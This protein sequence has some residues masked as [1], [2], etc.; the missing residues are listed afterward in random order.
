M[1]FYVNVSTPDNI[2]KRKHTG[3]G[4]TREM[5]VEAAVK[6]AAELKCRLLTGW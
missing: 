4:N 1:D 2:L 3:W 5:S 6:G